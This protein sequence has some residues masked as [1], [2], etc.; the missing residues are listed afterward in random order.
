MI[1]AP[2]GNYMG[3]NKNNIWG[4]KN[5]IMI[6]DKEH[7]GVC[8]GKSVGLK[9]AREIQTAAVFQMEI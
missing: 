4:C 8:G 1:K 6:F 9:A 2:N 3:N 5:R 7:V